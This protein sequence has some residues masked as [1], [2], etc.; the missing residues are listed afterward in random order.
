MKASDKL[1][2][3][4]LS[5]ILAWGWKRALIALVGSIVL[6]KA[7]D[8]QA[9]GVPVLGT[10]HS[11]APHFGLTGL[12]WTTLG[13]LAPLSAIVALVVLTQSAATT[14]AFAEQGGYDVDAGRIVPAAVDHLLCHYSAQSVRDE[15]VRVV[16]HRDDDVGADSAPLAF[17][18]GG[19][20]LD[21]GEE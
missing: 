15:S 16:R 13:N 17:Q 19:E 18:Q 4:G 7:F 5:I 11:G 12:S 9:H 21:H 3:A 1:R 20:D 8:L 10:V 2:S 6:V 14:R